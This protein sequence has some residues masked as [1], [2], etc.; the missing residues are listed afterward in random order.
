MI[1][2]WIIRGHGPVHRIAGRRFIH[3]SNQ[4]PARHGRDGVYLSHKAQRLP[5]RY[6]AVLH[7]LLLLDTQRYADE[8]PVLVLEE[9][10][11]LYYYSY[12]EA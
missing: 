9:V 4:N 2:D 5:R 8:D 6:S 12:P 11:W 3:L 7:L 1:G 10:G